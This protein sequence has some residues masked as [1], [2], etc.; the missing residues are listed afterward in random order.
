MTSKYWHVIRAA[1]FGAVVGLPCFTADANVK[2]GSIKP[3]MPGSAMFNAPAVELS[4][5]ERN[6]MLLL[7]QQIRDLLVDEAQKTMKRDVGLPAVT[8]GMTLL[9]RSGGETV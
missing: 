6:R 5:V 8:Q 3:I 9:P 7:R 1:G 4:P 2:S